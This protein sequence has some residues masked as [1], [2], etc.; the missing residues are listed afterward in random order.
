MQRCTA[1]ELRNLLDASPVHAR[2]E[3][4]RDFQQITHAR[5]GLAARNAYAAFLRKWSD[6][7][8][9]VARSFEE[10]GTELLTLIRVTAIDVEVASDDDL[11]GEP[12]PGVPPQNQDAVELRDGASSA[13]VAV[14]PRAFGQIRLR[15][16]DG[17]PDLGKLVL[18]DESK[19]A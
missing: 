14:R 8:S 16:I 11:A 7:C 12:Q 17:Y 18:D 2:A 4:K 10:T 15:K 6:L 1:H 19:A 13:D 5:D 9:Q 3:V